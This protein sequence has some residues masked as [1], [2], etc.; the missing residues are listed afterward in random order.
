MA[1]PTVLAA[2]APP[3][4]PPVAV[5]ACPGWCRSRH[6]RDVPETTRS[7][8]GE[9]AGVRA[10]GGTPLAVVDGLRIDAQLLPGQPRLGWETGEVTLTLTLATP[11]LPRMV[12]DL[13][14]QQAL[15]VA[16]LLADG[17]GHPLDLSALIRKAVRLAAPE[18]MCG[19]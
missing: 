13:S 1:N 5:P 9:L 4:G 15:Q 7:H 14:P 16:D 18:V 6:A 19:V 8:V 11:E 17:C 12:E 3:G 10:P 2:P